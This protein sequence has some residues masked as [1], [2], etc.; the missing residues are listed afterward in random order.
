VDASVSRLVAF[1]ERGDA[2]GLFTEDV[3]A[4]VT[5]PHWRVQTGSAADLI[6]ARGQMHPEPGRVRVEMVLGDE[7]AYAVKL[8]ERWESGGQDWYCRE[9]FLCELDE[10]GLVRGFHVYCTGDW[11]EQVVAQHAGAVSLLRP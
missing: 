10:A 8:E 5:L 7:T 1:L 6:A 4:D 3:F 11:D 2:A 9:A